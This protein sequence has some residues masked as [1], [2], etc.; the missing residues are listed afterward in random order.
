M[1]YSIY[2]AYYCIHVVV[3][4]ILGNKD[5]SYTLVA[6]RSVK[7]LHDPCSQNRSKLLRKFFVINAH[8]LMG[9]GASPTVKVVHVILVQDTNEKLQDLVLF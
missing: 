1:V 6:P 8:I 9:Q 3:P 7:T 4:G 2:V 5:A